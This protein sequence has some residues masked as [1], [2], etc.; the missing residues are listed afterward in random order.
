MIALLW[1][2]YLSACLHFSDHLIP[3]H[4]A[5]R[6]LSL[7]NWLKLSGSGIILEFLD[8]PICPVSSCVRVRLFS[9]GGGILDV[10]H[11]NENQ[12]SQC[13]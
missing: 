6:P 11:T 9:Q 8:S 13:P 3:T 1:A 5:F 7:L 10:F 12:R 2:A 4:S